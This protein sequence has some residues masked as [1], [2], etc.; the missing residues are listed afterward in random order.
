MNHGVCPIY[1]SAWDGDG[2]GGCGED[3]RHTKHIA[4]A[5]PPPRGSLPFET[6]MH[7]VQE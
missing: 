7:S 4:H 3:T 2:W 5:S 6:L 1:P